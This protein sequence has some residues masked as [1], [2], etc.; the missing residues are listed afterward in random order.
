[1]IPILPRAFPLLVLLVSLTTPAMAAKKSYGDIDGAVYLSNPDGDTLRMNIPGVPP[2][3]GENISIRIRGVDTPEIRGLCP[4][5][6]QLAQEASRQVHHLLASA[7]H[8]TLKDVG[9]DKYFRIVATVLADEV[10]VGAMLLNKGL[11]TPYDGGHKTKKWC[12]SP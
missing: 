6:K 3:L 7:G 2:L 10:D 11:A 12:E 4:R 8:I 9:R 1:M 5:E